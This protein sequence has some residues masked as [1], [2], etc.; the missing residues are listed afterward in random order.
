MTVFA[1]RFLAM[2]LCLALSAGAGRALTE[3]A[4]LFQAMREAARAGDWTGAEGHARRMPRQSALGETYLRWLRLRS[5]VGRWG[6]Y[7]RFLDRNAHWPGLGRLRARAERA[8]PARLDPASVRAFFAETLPQTG[9]GSLALAAALRAGGDGAAAR[10][11]IARSWLSLPLSAGEIARYRERYPEVV[12]PRIEARFDAMLWEDEPGA[13]RALLPLLPAG[14]GALADARQRLRALAPGVDAAIA[15]VPARFAD[16]PGLAFERFLWRARKGRA[17]EALEILE[18]RSR[19]AAAL[20][21]PAAWAERRARLAR[22][23]LRDGQAA[24]AYRVAARH[25]LED[26]ADFAALEWLAGY[27]ALTALSRPADALEHFTRFAGAVRTPIS[28]GRAGYWIGRAAEAAGDA[29]R[30]AEGYAL[31]AAHQTSFYGQLA[32]ERGGHP[33]DPALAAATPLPD[34]RGRRV[35][36]RAPLA[37]ARL[38]EAAG[39]PALARWFF[40]HTADVAGSEDAAALARYALERGRP[41]L[42]IRIAKAEARRGRILPAAYHPVTPLA[43]TAGPVPAPLA[44]AVARQESELNP[45]AISPAGARGLMQVMPRTA[46]AMADALGLAYTLDRLTEDPAYN[47]RLGTAYLARMLERYRGSTLLAAAAY[48]AGPGRVD[49]WLRRFGDPRQPGVDVLAWI[50]G[51]PFDE[52]RNYVMRVLEAVHVYRTRIE[53][54]PVAFSLGARLGG[55]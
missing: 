25:F 51:I 37:I 28:L 12:G 19:S 16:D 22:G 18:A 21:R 6:E 24:R 17:E 9:T 54:T 44:M 42:A 29:A 34:W 15:A 53:G 48:N 52:T 5:G 11:E 47:A 55:A 20:G 49:D 7:T 26:G 14:A 30:A 43:E 3:D 50:E 8:M 32:A 27:I 40:L 41:D 36:D 39:E 1:Q 31:G 35:M 23:L 46:R 10:A 4:A 13:A 38:F 2:I 45:T 33:P